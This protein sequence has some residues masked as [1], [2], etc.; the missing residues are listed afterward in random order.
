MNKYVMHL[1]FLKNLKRII[2][3]MMLSVVIVIVIL[4][5]NETME[6]LMETDEV[7]SLSFSIEES[8]RII[9]ELP[10]LNLPEDR[11]KIALEEDKVKLQLQEQK[12]QFIKKDNWKEAILVDL[13]LDEN[14][15]RGIK[16]GR[17]GGGEPVEVV[18]SRMVLNKELLDKNVEPTHEVYSTKGFNF[19]RSVANLFYSYV[20]IIFIV[21]LIGDILSREFER[22]TMKLHFSQ[23][24]SRITT[25][26]TKGIFALFSSLLIL[27]I[28][29]ITAFIS[30]S[31]MSGTGSIH[32]P[33]PFYS[34][35]MRF[36]GVG[37][38][39]LQSASLF[40]FALIF[41]ILITFLIAT[42]S[43]NS[44]ITVGLTIILIG[45]FAFG[46]TN[47]Q[48]L[49]DVAHLIPFTYIDTMNVVNGKLAFEMDNPS[50]NLN[51]GIL[52]MILFSI[53]LYVV[54]MFLIRKKDIF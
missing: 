32:Y 44:I 37:Q 5:L 7:K 12:L 49:A 36:M 13:Q 27:F 39:L 8:N 11:L 15:L 21:F 3:Y 22:G 34:D 1:E 52:I 2:F 19:T 6:S 35:P 9:R 45:V 31:I 24:L 42:I 51:N 29:T 14:F 38:Q 47:Y 4:F 28:I 48:F 10:N 40:V 25:L 18:E 17:I 41:I 54:T 23:P 50:I 20:G 33:V 43:R 46:V 30:G 53:I 16:S 26:N